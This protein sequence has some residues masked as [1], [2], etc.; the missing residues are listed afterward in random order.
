MTRAF[1]GIDVAFAKGKRLP[2]VVCTWKL[3]RLVPLALRRLQFQPP[4]GSGNA[5]SCVPSVVRQFAQSTAIYL[6]RVESHFGVQIDRIGI[7]A[8]SSPRREGARRRAA[9]VALDRAGISCFTTPTTSDFDSIREKVERH[10]SGGGAETHLPHANQ[11]WMQVGFELFSHLSSVAECVE[12]YPQATVRSLG[13]GAV[14]KSRGGAVEAQLAAISTYTGWP[15]SSRDEPSLAEIAWAPAHD[16]LDAYLSAWVAALDLDDRSPFGDPPDDVIWIPLVQE[17]PV[18]A[19]R[20]VAA[21][22][23]VNR[24]TPERGRT[25]AGRARRPL[26]CPACPNVFQDFPLGWDAHAAH[27]CSGLTAVEPDGRKREY[28]ERFGHLFKRYEA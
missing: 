13:A 19:V 10:L 23:P 18:T 3:G 1:V 26:Q 2:V 25:S 7:D 17:P 16:Q 11:L 24:H 14:H 15:D 5:Q 6:R 22:A 9:E 20:P 4:T 12:V 28:K 21:C 27:R 8:P